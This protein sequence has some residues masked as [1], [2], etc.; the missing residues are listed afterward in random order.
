MPVAVSGLEN[1]IVI[2]TRAG[3]LVLPRERA[4]DVKRLSEMIPALK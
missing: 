1:V 4:Q 3:V 2:A